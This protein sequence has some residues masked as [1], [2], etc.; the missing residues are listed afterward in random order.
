MDF[1]K[2]EQP[3]GFYAMRVVEVLSEMPDLRLGVLCS[4]I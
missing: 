4:S 1:G 3:E 2:N